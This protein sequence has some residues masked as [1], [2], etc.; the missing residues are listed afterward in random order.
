MRTYA[1][2]FSSVVEVASNRIVARTDDPDLQR[3]AMVWKMQVIP[4]A[5]SFLVV[6][7]PRLAFVDLWSLTEKIRVGSESD[8]LRSLLD[9]DLTELEEE[10]GQLN[11]QMRRIG[12]TFLTEEQVAETEAS[13]E[14]FAMDSQIGERFFAY[15]RSGSD[16][17]LGSFL[18]SL[19]T[20]PLSALNPFSGVS[21]TAVAIHDVAGS[22]D[23][24]RDVVV[25]TPDELRWQSEL[26][27]HDFRNSPELQRTLTS[28]ESMTKTSAEF[29]AIARELPQKV[30]LEVEGL[31][32]DVGEAQARLNA[33][34]DQ[35]QATLQQVEPLLDSSQRVTESVT[36]AG[37][38]LEK[39]FMAFD[40]SMV[41]ILGTP[42][43]RAAA[44]ARRD[45]NEESEPF[46][47]LDYAETAE[48][49]TLT[50]A[51][52]RALL[53]EVQELTEGERS[54]E[55]VD[56]ANRTTASVV[57]HLALRVGQLILAATA[58]ALLLRFLWA[59]LG[60]PVKS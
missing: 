50:A 9:L 57:D 17:N 52:L 37:T 39:T 41:T 11:R 32:D 33:T 44:A 28:L 47:I 14:A 1:R 55:L 2:D 51:E 21:E 46:R 13:I 34:L 31:L 10:M 40:A 15:N 6:D 25:N 12:S 23:L 18:G 4:L 16:V 59:R 27:M 8:E 42:E 22:A 19:V 20:T 43:A 5:Q 49:L 36:E 60:A 35:V 30:R 58:C 26:V 45:P 56:L 48:R 54:E 3:R 38:A 7:D 29:A 53:D 24:I